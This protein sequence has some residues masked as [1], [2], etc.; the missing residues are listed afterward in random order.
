[1]FTSLLARRITISGDLHWLENSKPEILYLIRKNISIPQFEHF[2]SKRR[3]MER[4]YQMF[5]AERSQD[6]A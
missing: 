3:M 2:V 5:E 6:S 1:M 4:G